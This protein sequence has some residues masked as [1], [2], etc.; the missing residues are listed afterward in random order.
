MVRDIRRT[1]AVLRDRMRRDLFSK[2]PPTHT[3]RTLFLQYLC[4]EDDAVSARAGHALVMAARLTPAV[5]N[6]AMHL[7]A[8]FHR[9]ENDEIARRCLELIQDII[10]DRS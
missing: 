3:M 8:E 10:A 5:I 6:A 7:F 1:L 4:D 2:P 9:S